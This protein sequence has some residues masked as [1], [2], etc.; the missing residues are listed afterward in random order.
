M[1]AL[2]AWPSAPIGIGRS[3]ASD[4]A[5][6]LGD[7]DAGA[8]AFVPSRASRRAPTPQKNPAA[9]DHC[10]RAQVPPSMPTP[11][12]GHGAQFSSI[13]SRSALCTEVHRADV[14]TAY[15][16]AG[17]DR[18]ATKHPYK[19]SHGLHA[20]PNAGRMD[21]CIWLGCDWSLDRCR[22]WAEEIIAACATSTASPQ[23]SRDHRAVPRRQPRQPRTD[24]GRVSQLSAP[25]I[26]SAG[27]A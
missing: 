11:N 17:C 24:A 10:G 7:Y 20:G 18:S 3:A 9:R 5:K 6:R 14:C 25:V 13:R 8:R 21:H 1:L 23:P 26:C 22:I 19:H 27:E 4:D 16:Q 15:P 12:Q 2:A